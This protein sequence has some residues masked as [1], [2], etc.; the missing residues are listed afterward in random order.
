MK[1]DFSIKINN[2]K[3]L[4]NSLLQKSMDKS[5]FR[6]K[7]FV[8]SNN[9][10]HLVISINQNTSNSLS[11]LGIIKQ[12]FKNLPELN[13]SYFSVKSIENFGI[14]VFA[15][16][17]DLENCKKFAP[18]LELDNYNNFSEKLSIWENILA[19]I[20]NYNFAKTNFEQKSILI[21]FNIKEDNLT[22]SIPQSEQKEIPE[23]LSRFYKKIGKNNV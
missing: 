9:L 7:Q 12:N 14:Y 21:D 6:V 18:Y 11:I 4:F 15:G 23:A 20:L 17:P 8:F 5:D 22:L 13:N 2:K 16:R 10:L 3:L 1:P 19:G